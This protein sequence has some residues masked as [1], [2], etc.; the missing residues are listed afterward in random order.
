MSNIRLTEIFANIPIQY[1]DLQKGQIDILIIEKYNDIKNEISKYNDI[2]NEISKYNNNNNINIDISNTEKFINSDKKY[3]IIYIY[4]S[5]IIHNKEIINKL[6]ENTKIM[7]IKHE[8]YKSFMDY[9]W[10]KPTQN[11]N[12]K[13]KHTITINNVIIEYHSNQIHPINT[14]LNF[15]NYNINNIT[16]KY[17]KPEKHFSYFDNNNSD[18]N[19]YT[20]G[21]HIMLDF[22]NVDFDLLENTD[23]ILELMNNIAISENFVVLNK[24]MHKFNPQ[25]FTCIFLLS[26]SHFSIHTYPEYNKCS[27]DLYSCDEKINYNNIIIKLKNGLK[28]ENFKLNQV[29][30]K[31]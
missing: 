26:T 30:R 9:F 5:E 14:F 23:Y 1:F 20:M 15:N 31:I 24:T 22:A 18:K 3:D 25:G 6:L 28:S 11:I 12:S 2:T 7:M 29:I 17:Y 10:I 21:I 8:E 16:S 13:Y 27:I 19:E 4:D